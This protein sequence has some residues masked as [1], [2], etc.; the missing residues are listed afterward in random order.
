M[1]YA[2]DDTL[3]RDLNLKIENNCLPL[4]THW[5]MVCHF[6]DAKPL[7]KPPALFIVNWTVKKSAKFET[8]Y[9]QIS[10]KNSSENGV[11]EIVAMMLSPRRL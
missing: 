9:Q 7:S 11:C 4:K 1:T 10:S 8:E 2:C 6:F 5:V 3:T